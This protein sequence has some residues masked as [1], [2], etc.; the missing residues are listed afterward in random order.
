MIKPCAWNKPKQVCLRKGG[1]IRISSITG[2]SQRES[3]DK[4]SLSG[5]HIYREFYVNLQQII[6]IMRNQT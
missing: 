1:H 2:S 6:Q 4:I 3:A 5:W